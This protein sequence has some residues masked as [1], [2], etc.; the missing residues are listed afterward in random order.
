MIHLDSSVLLEL[1]LGGA[2]AQE[3]HELLDGTEAK[4]AS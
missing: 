4:V 2:R 1:Y 3:A